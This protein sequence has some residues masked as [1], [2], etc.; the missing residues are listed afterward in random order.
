MLYV[1]VGNTF[2]NTSIMTCLRGLMVTP[3]C[4]IL[5]GIDLELSR[6]VCMALVFKFY[7]MKSPEYMPVLK[8]L[9]AHRGRLC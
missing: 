7:E 8:L 5:A 9:V 4:Y 2:A 1:D 3:E 6:A